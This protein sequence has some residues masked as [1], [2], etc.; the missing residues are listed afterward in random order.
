MASQEDRSSNHRQPVPEELQWIEWLTDLLDSKFKIPGTKITFGIDPII[1]LVPYFGEIVS[2]GISGIL[3]LSM[4]RHGASGKVVTRMLLNLAVDAL[5]GLIPGL[6]DF[7][8]VF[9]KA[10]RRNYK[11]LLEHQAQDQ[12]HGSAWPV[13]IGVTTVILIMLALMIWGMVAVASWIISL[14]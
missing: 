11:L 4:V 5:T 13:L 14:F 12:H 7:F 9:F 3:V 1:G 2:F 10:N 6:G 8:D